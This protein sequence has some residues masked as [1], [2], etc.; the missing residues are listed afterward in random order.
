MGPQQ[1]GLASLKAR[2]APNSVVNSRKL[3]LEKLI[4]RGVT[5]VV[6]N[7]PAGS[8]VVDSACAVT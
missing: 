1:I 3:N 5:G 2:Y 8:L 7:S 6:I 4:D